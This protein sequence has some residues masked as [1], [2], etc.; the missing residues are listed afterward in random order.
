MQ[1]VKDSI[2]VGTPLLTPSV[3]VQYM[4]GALQSMGRG[5][6]AFEVQVGSFLPRN[7]DL[8]TTRFL[9]SQAEW[10]MHIDSDIGWR[11]EQVERLVS[12]GKSFI[13]GVYCK[14][15]P[16]RDIPIRFREECQG[17]I[18][19]LVRADS[20]PGGFLLVHRE[21]LLDM[22]AARKSYRIGSGTPFGDICGLWSP[23]HTETEYLSEDVSFCR[24][25]TDL[26]GQIWVDT[27]VV[28]DHYDGGTRYNPN[29]T[30][31][32]PEA[33]D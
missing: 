4:A 30:S 18:D 17:E 7:R 8:L 16:A 32:R 13:S 25:W 15:T 20:V 3:H 24:R 23:I 6:Y 1:Y 12:H 14:K 21:A 19:E 26:G 28:V 22:V 9:A 5:R 10:C 11:P 31:L 29:D 2:W 27:S 33:G